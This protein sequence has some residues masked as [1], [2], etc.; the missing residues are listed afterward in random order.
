MGGVFSKPKA[1]PPPP[2][3]PPTPTPADAAPAAADARRQ[4]GKRYGRRQT[5]LT[6]GQGAVDEATIIRKTLLGA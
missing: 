1:P 4:A 5:I 3:P 6:S 2:P